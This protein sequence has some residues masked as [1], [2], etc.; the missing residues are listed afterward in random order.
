MKLSVL[1]TFYNQEEYVN[2]AI[3][4]ILSQ[5]TNFDFE[6]LI[7]DDGSTDGTREIIQKW[8]NR[9]PNKIKLFTRKR[10]INKKY[11][12]GCRAS[13]NR[14]NLLRHVKSE[15]FMFLDGDDYLCDNYKFEKQITILENPENKDC[16]A[17]AHNVLKVYENEGNKREYLILKS[18]K[19]QK[20]DLETYWEKY[21]FHPDSII[22]RSCIIDKIPYN[23]LRYFFNDNLITYW[24]L[25]HGK[26][27]YIPDVMANYCQTGNG[28][29]T[30]QRLLVGVTRNLMAWEIEN[31][32]NPN[33]KRQCLIRHSYD[34]DYFYDH[35]DELDGNDFK[36]YIRLA[37]KT[38]LVQCSKW[39][40]Y[41]RM[42]I[43]QRIEFSVEY[44]IKK[45]YLFLYKCKMGC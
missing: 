29:W 1:V 22:C 41:P 18:F 34:F 16:V 37:R 14:L 21:Y 24:M 23:E 44:F 8:I 17:C 32:L 20:I 45:F 42:N 40:S 27:Y 5:E 38:G 35:R 6:V 9:Y 12:S 10:D 2:R 30:G 28:I 33:L 43:V 31:R 4:S 36:F 11:N 15:Y 7:G 26:I 19:E 13:L 25:Q 3:E 39:L